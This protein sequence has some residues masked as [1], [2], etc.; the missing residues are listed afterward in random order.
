MISNI[1]RRGPRRPQASSEIDLS[2]S[3]SSFGAC[4]CVSVCLHACH[5]F[6]GVIR[7]RYLLRLKIR[8]IV[9]ALPDLI[10]ILFDHSVFIVVY[11]YSI[12]GFCLT[13]IPTLCM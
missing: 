4:W 12:L 13:P 7:A 6:G 8:R 3:L 10:L 1:G 9:S 5:I 11:F 2:L